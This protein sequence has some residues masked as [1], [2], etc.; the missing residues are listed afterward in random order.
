MPQ[1]RI[2][3][4]KYTRGGSRRLGLKQEEFSPHFQPSICRCTATLLPGA[5]SPWA[6]V[7]H[8]DWSLG[9]ETVGQT[10]VRFVSFL[11]TSTSGEEYGQHVCTVTM[12]PCELAVGGFF[13]DLDNGR[14]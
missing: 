4:I 11:L 14:K 6:G 13:P 8:L 5:L 10:E 12:V 1:D 7:H 3:Q 2:R 9:R